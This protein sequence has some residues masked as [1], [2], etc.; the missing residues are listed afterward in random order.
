MPALVDRL[1]AM[2]AAIEQQS[3]ALNERLIAS[4]DAS[5]ARPRPP[6][7]GL[8]A[9]V[10]AVVE[11]EPRPKAPAPPARR[12]SRSSRPRWP[13]SRARRPRC[14]TPSTHA[15]AAATRRAVDPLRG[16]APPR[17]RTSGTARSPSTSERA[18]RCPATCAPRW[19]L[20]RDLRAA[21]GSLVDGVADA[22]GKHGGQRVGQRGAGALAQQERV[23]ETLAGQTRSR[24]WRRPR[25]P[26]S[27]TRPRCCARRPGARGLADGTGIARRAAAGGLDAG[28]R[29]D[30]RLA[31]AASGSRR[32]RAPRASSRRSA[33]TL[34]RTARDI[35][36]QTEAH[37][38]EHDRRDRPAHA[39][40]VRS[41]RAP[42]PKSIAELR[43]KL[44]DSMVARQR[45]AGGAQPHPRQRWKRC[46]TP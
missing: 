4:Q 8:A 21:L 42:R 28:A 40:R 18:R 25:R 29:S 41:A 43:Q 14:T 22:P 36:A 35:S 33:T 7:R 23:S 26:S 39:G 10:G 6:I 30:G 9:S 17:W 32:A 19:T 2:M 3:Q 46:S 1:Q 34:A 13:A 37:A 16:D 12:S 11:G 24:R 27:S 44:S 45:D 31:A 20:R 15:R 38:S 5:T